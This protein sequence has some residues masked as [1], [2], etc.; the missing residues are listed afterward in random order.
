MSVDL[1]APFS[2]N[3][4]V[5]APRRISKSTPFSAWVGP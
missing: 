2:P 5:T 4:T 1:P 3:S